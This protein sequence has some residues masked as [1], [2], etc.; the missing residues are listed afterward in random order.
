MDEI[1]QARERVQHTDVR[2]ELESITTS[3]QEMLDAEAGEETD[4]DEAFAETPFQGAAPSPDN[5]EELETHLLKLAEN[6]ER[7]DVRT[8]LEAAQRTLASY[9]IERIDRES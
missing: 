3:L 2:T 6:V 4:P 7:A 1:G 9:R 8:H 5:V